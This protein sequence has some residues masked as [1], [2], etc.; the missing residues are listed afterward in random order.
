MRAAGIVFAWLVVLLLVACGGSGGGAA[1]TVEVRHQ[2]DVA[3]RTPG[4]AGDPGVTVGAVVQACRTKDVDA[5][6]A[7][8]AA[9]VSEE[10]VRQMFAKGQDVQLVSQSIPDEPGDRATI[11]VTL[12]VTSDRGETVVQRSWELARGDEGAWVLTA[13]PECY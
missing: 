11:D 6:R 3:T 9:G 10:E 1:P 7:L 2:T 13:L 5:L 12:R 8:I 4:R